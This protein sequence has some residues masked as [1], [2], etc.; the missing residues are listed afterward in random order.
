MDG[1]RSARVPRAVPGVT[2]RTALGKLVWETGFRHAAEN[3][4]RD[5]RAPRSL[6]LSDAVEALLIIGGLTVVELPGTVSA[7]GVGG[8]GLPDAGGGQ[9]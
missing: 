6:R 4:N 7:D 9:I 2:P 8:D 3:G 1:L 5:S